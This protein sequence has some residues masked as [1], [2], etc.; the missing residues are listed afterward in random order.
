MQWLI[1]EWQ[2][3]GEREREGEVAMGRGEGRGRFGRVTGK[4]R[5]L[6][7]F[8]AALRGSISLPLSLPSSLP[9][10]LTLYT[11]PSLSPPLSP[12]SLLPTLFPFPSGQSCSISYFLRAGGI[13]R[14]FAPQKW[15]LWRCIETTDPSPTGVS[16][17]A[18]ARHAGPTLPCALFGAS[19]AQRSSHRGHGFSSCRKQAFRW[20][21]DP[22]L[23]ESPVR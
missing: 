17:L 22:S 16:T 3:G 20:R 10:S 4:L 18:S 13:A 15:K 6:D 12:S 19:S 21:W 7:D 23:G 14:S 5:A 8:K 1:V 11:P 9:L 2:S